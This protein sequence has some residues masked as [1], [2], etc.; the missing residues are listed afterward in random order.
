M[1]RCALS[2]ESTIPL[3]FENVFG[4]SA[5]V[6]IT[7]SEGPPVEGLPDWVLPLGIVTAVSIALVIGV[8]VLTRGGR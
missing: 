8:K 5:E 2:A 1:P 3:L 4:K 7:A 6:S